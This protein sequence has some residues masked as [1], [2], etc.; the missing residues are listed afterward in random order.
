MDYKSSI[1]FIGGGNMAEALAVG[2]VR[3]GIAQAD[4]IIISEPRPER[5]EHLRQ[6][7]GFNVT[8]ENRQAAVS[9]GTVFLAVKPQVLPYVLDE[10][11]GSFQLKNLVISTAAGITLGFLEKHLKGIPVIRSMPN[12]PALIATGAT[13]IAPGSHVQTDM[14]QWAVE[15]FQATGICHVLPEDLMDAV[16]GLSGSGPAYL[17]LMAEVLVEAGKALGIPV[18]QASDL[19]KQT[20]LGA[21]RMMTET[22]KTP[23]ELREMVT[24]PGG[25]TEAA[26]KSME[27]AGFEKIVVEAVKAATKRAR[28]LGKE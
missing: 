25:T 5:C 15:L 18:E 8:C 13:V 11:S 6:I 20:I 1:S 16:T 26:L 23:D 7:H 21:G 22:G 17:F 14:T 2:I 4:S 27:E 28:E 19:V 24:S 12:T 9:G 3:A 10:I